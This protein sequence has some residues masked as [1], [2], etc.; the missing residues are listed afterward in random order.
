MRMKDI[1]A[2]PTMSE[3]KALDQ[4]SGAIHSEPAQ[5]YGDEGVPHDSDDEPMVYE[6]PQDYATS[7][8]QERDR[9]IAEGADPNSVILQSELRNHI[10]RQEGESSA[11]F[12]KRYAETM[13]GMIDRGVSILNDQCIA[14]VVAS[15]FRTADGRFFDLGPG[16][17]ATKREFREFSQWFPEM[18]EEGR[19]HEVP[20]KWLKFEKPAKG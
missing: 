11:D 8:R 1:A 9:L 7:A 6:T 2:A 3:Q 14:D 12:A 16:S 17:G 13:K 18:S 10:L 4:Q 15:G 19:I 20:E 5:I